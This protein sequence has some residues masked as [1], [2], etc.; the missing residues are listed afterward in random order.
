MVYLAEREDL[1]SLVAMKV[2][3][4]AWVSP[5][6][7]ER[8]T[9]EQRTLAQL[10]HPFIARI[11]DAD[12]L[13]DGTPW[14][15]MEYVEGRSLTEYCDARNSPLPERLR[16]FRDVCAAVQHAHQRLIVHRD[17]KPSNIFVTESGMVKLLD[18]GIAKQLETLDGSGDDTRTARP[19]HDACVCRTRADPRRAA[20]VCRPMSMR[21]ASCCTRSSP[22][23]GPSTLA[24][25][26]PSEAEAII[27]ERTAQRPS[28]VNRTAPRPLSAGIRRGR[29]WTCCA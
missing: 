8:F 12:A 29:I 14:F 28:L 20:Q 19:A 1:G 27:L 13:A 22:D 4:D 24:N 7:R 5:A 10:N 3:R 15:A 9:S 25:R 21:S 26:T 2:L 23:G 6:R 11:Y 17:L 16:L 18:F